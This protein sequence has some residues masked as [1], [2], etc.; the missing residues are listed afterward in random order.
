M[1]LFLAA[2]TLAATVFVAV[3]G[4]FAEETV[5]HTY[6]TDR[7]LTTESRPSVPSGEAARSA[8]EIYLEQHNENMGQ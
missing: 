5:D 7:V 2:L 6:Y 1:R 4:V 3:T 8:G